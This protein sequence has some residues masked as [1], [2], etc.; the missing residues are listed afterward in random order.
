MAGC[1]PSRAAAGRNGLWSE[2]YLALQLPHNID[3][4]GVIG[5]GGGE[6]TRLR[7]QLRCKA[8]ADVQ[9]G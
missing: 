7:S 9:G 2:K 8:A 5:S 4:H 1:R 6:S 3:L